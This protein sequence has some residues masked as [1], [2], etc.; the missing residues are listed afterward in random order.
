MTTLRDA[1]ASALDQHESGTLEA[2]VETAIETDEQPIEASEQE[3]RARDEAGRFK[4]KEEAKEQAEKPQE[5]AQEAPPA[6]KPPSSWKKDYWS[7]WERLGADPELSQLQ[8][9]I[10]QREADY[11]KGVS[12]Y[13]QQWDQAQPVF[14]AIQP[15]MPELQQ[16]GIQP[17]Q[18]IQNLGSA[19]RALALGTPEQKLQM[20]AKLATDYGV[21][22]QAL[23]GQAGDPQFAQ[24][25]PVISDLQRKVQMMEQQTQA[26]E[27]ARLQRDIEAFKAEA[28]MFEEARP[29]MARLLESGMAS[30]LKD[31]YQK[32]IRLDEDLWSKHQAEQAKGELQE[33]QRIAA[34]KKA[35]AVSPKSASP[36]GSMAAG[37]TKKGLRDVLSEAIDTHVGGRF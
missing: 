28:P 1:L 12:T 25:I 31:A 2:P 32:A 6:R 5:A 21:P 3:G 24:A 23:T 30:D 18:W 10:E 27:Q 15:F 8:D 35:K 13:K 34:E 36:T 20:F 11:A 29:H 33:R 26:A 9:Y 22:I 4:A 14:E 37:N 19:H 16:Y 7:H 17:Q